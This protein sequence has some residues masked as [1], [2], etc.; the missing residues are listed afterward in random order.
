MHRSSAGIAAPA[1]LGAHVLCQ[2]WGKRCSG[3]HTGPG[4]QWGVLIAGL[5]TSHS[6]CAELYPGHKPLHTSS[7]PPPEACW[8]S[9]V[10]AAPPPPAATL[11]AVRSTGTSRARSTA[12]AAGDSGAAPAQAAAQAALC[13]DKQPLTWYRVNSRP[14]QNM[15]KP[16]LR[17]RQCLLLQQIHLLCEQLLVSFR[18]Y[19]SVQQQRHQAGLHQASEVAL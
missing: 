2:R 16:A 4:W 13:S 11:P 19:Q 8:S 12:S 9:C 6:V 10:S 14:H 3:L 15:R 17:P 1:I 18:T 7:L 5:H